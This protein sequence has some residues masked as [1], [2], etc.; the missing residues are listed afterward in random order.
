MMTSSI[1]G[2]VEGKV[3]FWSSQLLC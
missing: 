2:K 3:K 1:I